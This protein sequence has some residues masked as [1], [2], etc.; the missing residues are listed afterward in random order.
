MGHENRRDTNFTLKP[1]LLCMVIDNEYAKY[2]I[3]LLGDN[4]FS[5]SIFMRIE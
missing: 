5:Q 1:T 3:L 4:T 2:P